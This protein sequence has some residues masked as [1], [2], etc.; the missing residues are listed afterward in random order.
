MSHEGVVVLR[1]WCR[2]CVSI[3]WATPHAPVVEVYECGHVCLA[4]LE[5]TRHRCCLCSG[6]DAVCP[7]CAER[8]SKAPAADQP[9]DR[10][11]TLASK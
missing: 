6:L 7:I 3:T 11:L 4:P 9:D 8:R 10:Q 2:G 5:V 1:R